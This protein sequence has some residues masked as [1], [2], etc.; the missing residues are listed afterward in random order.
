LPGAISLSFWGVDLLDSEQ[1]IDYGIPSWS[2]IEIRENPV[3][4]ICVKYSDVSVIFQYR[5]ETVDSL[6]EIVP[7][8]FHN[9]P[10]EFDF[11]SGEIVVNGSSHLREFN[12]IEI[13]S[14]R[15]AV[16]IECWD[17][18][19]TCTFPCQC[20]VGDALSALKRDFCATDGELLVNDAVIVNQHRPLQFCVGTL[21]LSLSRRYRFVVHQ[22]KQAF[23]DTTASQ[24]VVEVELPHGTTVADA[25]VRLVWIMGAEQQFVMI[26]RDGRDL[27]DH[28]VLADCA[29][30]SNL[31]VHIRFKTDAKLLSDQVP[32]FMIPKRRSAPLSK[33]GPV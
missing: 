28:F 3:G 23:A 33:S 21:R 16:V 18:P 25:K 20:T 9:L 24:N 7:F 6:R 32:E 26:L 31:L 22:P 1:F 19:H 2:E 17:G 30:E 10:Q 12:E 13:R 27:K 11:V 14:S 8:H 4:Q 5:F 15:F 29:G